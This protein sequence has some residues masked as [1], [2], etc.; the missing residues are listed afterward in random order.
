[1]TGSWP[2]GHRPTTGRIQWSETTTKPGPSLHRE[3]TKKS[4]IIV[5]SPSPAPVGVHF[6]TL[7]VGKKQ[8]YHVTE[9][10]D[11]RQSDS[12]NLLGPEIWQR[13]GV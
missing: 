7:P 12:L 3:P 5:I 2:L 13:Q 1:M 4:E 9:Q 11:G 10:E 8:K 6:G